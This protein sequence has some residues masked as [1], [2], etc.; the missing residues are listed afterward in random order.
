MELLGGA[1]VR[2]QGTVLGIIA[3]EVICKNSC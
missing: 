2:A 1:D 3:E